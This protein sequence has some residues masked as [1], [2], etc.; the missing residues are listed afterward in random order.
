MGGKFAIIFW[1]GVDEPAGAVAVDVEGEGAGVG[2]VV[3]V[4]SGDGGFGEL[5]GGEICNVK[6]NV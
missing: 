6:G 2:T 4:V 5:S 3:G 1:G